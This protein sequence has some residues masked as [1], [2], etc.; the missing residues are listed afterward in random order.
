MTPPGPNQNSGQES[1]SREL[2]SGQDKEPTRT[3]ACTG[4]RP[5][6]FDDS[7]NA[8]LETGHASAGA[9]EKLRVDMDQFATDLQ[10]FSREAKVASKTII[11]MISRVC[12]RAQTR[13]DDVCL[14]LTQLETT[15]EELNHC[16]PAA[17]TTSGVIG[18]HGPI[19]ADT[20]LWTAMVRGTKTTL[21]ASVLFSLV[22][23]LQTKVDLLSE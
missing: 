5:F 6:V 14:R 4:A 13:N 21:T 2:Q 15:V 17:G 12:S 3:S 19:G 20:P 10:D 7:V 23:E 18:S 1:Q 8:A 11:K 22:L 16:S 9:L